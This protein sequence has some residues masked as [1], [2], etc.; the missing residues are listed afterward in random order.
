MKKKILSF[1]LTVSLVMAAVPVYANSTTTSI[2]IGCNHMGIVTEDGQLV[3][4]GTMNM[5]ILV[6]AL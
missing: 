5:E 3:M 4:W 1:I 6:L 2:G